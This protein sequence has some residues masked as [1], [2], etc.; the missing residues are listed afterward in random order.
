LSTIQ[1]QNEMLR[2]SWL[3]VIPVAPANHC[4][5][6]SIRLTV[7]MGV[8]KMRAASRARSSSTTGR[9]ASSRP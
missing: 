7:D 6:R 5:S 1:A 4:R 9:A 2:G 3:P 8:S